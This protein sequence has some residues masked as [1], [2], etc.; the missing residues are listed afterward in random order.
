MTA[1]RDQ[2][3]LLAYVFWHWKQAARVLFSAP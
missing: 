1:S 2:G 3:G